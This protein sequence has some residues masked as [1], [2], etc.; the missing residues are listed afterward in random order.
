M[1]FLQPPDDPA[2]LRPP[3][4]TPR[5]IRIEIAIVLVVTLG[6]SGLRS[7]VS[8][9]ESQIRAAQA[10]ATLSSQA[11]SVVAPQSS[12]GWVD[13]TRQVLSITQGLTWGLLGVYL[14]WRAGVDLKGRLGLDLKRPGRD[15][16][17]GVGLAALIGLPGLGLYLLSHALGFSLTVVASSLTDTWWR[18][19][20]S[21]LAAI[22]NG[23]LE[24]ILV[25]GY[26][27]T[28]LEHLRV[29]WW[30]A[31]LFSALLRGSYHLYQGYGGFVGNAL[32][33]VLFALYFLRY[34]RLW[35]LVIA[36]S[37]IDIVVFVAYPLLHGSVS[38]L[39]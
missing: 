19:P 22:E 17:H 2:Q 12:L 4:E 5:A 35:P 14:L 37:L 3:T 26:L 32:M 16:L 23:F 29:R 39:P 8:I 6:M 15:A 13:L 34:R 38:W 30:V 27:L 11:V 7:L 10:G 28:R 36:H 20:V 25:V 9:I 31:I 1:R 24:E 21:I 33:G 18:I